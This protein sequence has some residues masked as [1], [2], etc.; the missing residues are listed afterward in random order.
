MLF[1]PF[2]GSFVSSAGRSEGFSVG[3]IVHFISCDTADRSHEAP[4]DGPAK[5]TRLHAKK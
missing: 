3:E 4:V 5:N 2:A 1:L